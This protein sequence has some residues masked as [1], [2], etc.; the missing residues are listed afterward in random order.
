MKIG[1]KVVCVDDAPCRCCGTTGHFIK[2]QV[3]VIIEMFVFDD[4]LVFQ[5]LGNYFETETHLGV[6][7]SRFRLLDHLKEASKQAKETPRT[8]VDNG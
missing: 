8:I 6:C 5:L 3:Y 7:A 4:I 1:D 2:G